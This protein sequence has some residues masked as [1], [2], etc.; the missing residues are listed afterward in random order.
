MQFDNPNAYSVEPLDRAGKRRADPAWL[1]AA[2]QAPNTRFVAFHQRRPLLREAEAGLDIAWISS[3][4]AAEAEGTDLFLGLAP[5]GE[6]VFARQTANEHFSD[7][8]AYHDLMPASARLEADERAIIGTAKALF[9]WHARHGF[10]A[11]CGAATTMTEAGWRRDCPQCSAQHFPRVDPVVIMLLTH[12]DRC[13]LG[14]APRFP[15]RMVSALAGFVEPGETLA[16]AIARETMEEAG[17]KVVSFSMQFTQPWPFPSSLMIGAICEV[18]S[19]DFTLDLDE[20][21]EARWFT[22]ADIEDL[23]D[24]RHADFSCPPRTAIAHQL[25]RVWIGAA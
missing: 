10:C 9:E 21:A 1:A 15:G 8:G 11:N 20:V 16:S 12:K 17:L 6:A 23:L 18:E 24:G 14:R 5:Q 2:L 19:D 22:R 7:A 4:R 13:F 3:A 25:L